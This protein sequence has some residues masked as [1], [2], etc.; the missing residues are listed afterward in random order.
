MTVRIEPSRFCSLFPRLLVSGT[1]S[2]SLKGDLAEWE[3]ATL[4]VDLV[5][6]GLTDLKLYEDFPILTFEDLALF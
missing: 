3:L 1:P 5:L 4:N 6:V 2:S